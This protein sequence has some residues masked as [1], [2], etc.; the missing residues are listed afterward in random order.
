MEAGFGPPFAS[1]ICVRCSS[2]KFGD[3]NRYMAGM[4]ITGLLGTPQ[5]TVLAST[6]LVS[7]QGETAE[8]FTS[9]FA[10]LKNASGVTPD[11]MPVSAAK[12]NTGSNSPSGSPFV[13]VGLAPGLVSFGNSIPTKGGAPAAIA[14]TA[15]S[16]Q[17][18]SAQSLIV[19]S[20]DVPKEK[21]VA[22]S[23]TSAPPST[24]V[25]AGSV[26]NAV[27]TNIESF[28]S[29][30]SEVDTILVEDGVASDPVGSFVST[31]PELLEKSDLS[32]SDAAPNPPTPPTFISKTGLN[33]PRGQ[34][35]AAL[36][37]ST[38]KP[39]DDAEMVSSA[40]TPTVPQQEKSLEI[41]IEEPIS[42]TPAFNPISAEP[43]A[44]TDDAQ[45][46][47]G[48]ITS[49]GETL[50]KRRD[51]SPKE[52]IELPAT[53]DAAYMQPSAEIILTATQSNYA[54]PV[55]AAT[56]P[57]NAAAGGEPFS[58]NEA[59]ASPD[60]PLAY[61][62]QST[63]ASGTYELE[64]GPSAP[65]RL[66]RPAELQKPAD[67]DPIFSDAR[68]STI[69][70]NLEPTQ[71]RLS[72]ALQAQT[73]QA[74]NVLAALTALPSLPDSEA[75]LQPIPVPAATANLR[76]FNAADLSLTAAPDQSQSLAS[77]NASNNAQAFGAAPP[78]PA[79]AGSPVAVI[80]AT[81]TLAGTLETVDDSGPL[82]GAQALFK[83]PIS[84]LAETLLPVGIPE[85]SQIA[86]QNI[87][88]SVRQPSVKTTI[89]AA[90]WPVTPLTQSGANTSNQRTLNLIALPAL[91][92]VPLPQPAELGPVS[93]TLAV[94]P[95]EEAPPFAA[96][97]SG[98]GPS[99]LGVAPKDLVQSAP[100]TN[101]SAAK[102][103]T[104]QPPLSGSAIVTPETDIAPGDSLGIGAVSQ[105]GSSN[106]ADLQEAQQG[107]VS[108][109]AS[110][111]AAQFAIP[112]RPAATRFSPLGAYP[113]TARDLGE[114]TPDGQRDNGVSPTD[115]LAGGA[116]ARKANSAPNADL[117]AQT[118]TQ[119]AQPS[120][121]SA[122]TVA[123]PAQTLN[124]VSPSPS[125]IVALPDEA[126]ISVPDDSGFTSPALSI[127]EPE[128]SPSA[129]FSTERP[130]HTRAH[131]E[132]PQLLGQMI[133]RRADSGLRSFA[134]RLDPAEL[135][136][137]DV[138]LTM[139][140]DRKV[141]A[142]LSVERP[143]TL[144][145]LTRASREITRALLDAG[146][147][148]ADGGLSFSLNEHSRGQQNWA[149]PKVRNANADQNSDPKL[150][151]VPTHSANPQRWGRSRLMLE[152]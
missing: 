29:N 93:N 134:V 87:S 60:G 23:A 145:D 53:I 57:P 121:Q 88:N 26:P 7:S 18:P 47:S 74:G 128:S 52:T 12:P 45:I 102:R 4:E 113:S 25:G 143:E 70:G 13:V 135:G 11:I 61:P 131:A 75:G 101:P 120:S 17:N 58:A 138:T 46:A 39:T 2:A 97:V 109:P 123:I 82:E 9:V 37:A 119:A 66:S 50:P 40:T 32:A 76:Q 105:D 31:R 99:S 148:L 71:S 28:V 122:Q 114:L 14:F 68:I 130:A 8:G 147:D 127:F 16:A 95:Q 100:S 94:I 56:T 36:L 73:N 20:F 1:S 41:G 19:V 64:I 110:Q 72:P 79:Q 91:A 125:A 107:A 5:S 118:A 10:A 117:L 142:S 49:A 151:P 89:S 15:F 59:P 90:A 116:I 6:G 140:K 152:A 139:T 55:I 112:Q 115:T 85:K 133:A 146:L 67:P 78:K 48:T 27:G 62:L 132:T 124:A 65:Q 150:E 111:L 141:T 126:A 137:V 92:P 44:V 69:K 103:N 21:S 83:T 80:A 136:R 149:E 43:A 51:V 86:Q 77:A 84:T 63:T 96:P 81:S 108:A 38:T 144:G 104:I 98:S 33:L 129:A 22:P 34:I 3:G 35:K 24:L 54:S 106:S 42:P 30:T